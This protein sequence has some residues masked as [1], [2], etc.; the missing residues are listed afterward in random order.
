[1]HEVKINLDEFSS[2]CDTI[3]NLDAAT[4]GGIENKH[5]VYSH[6]FRAFD[7]DQVN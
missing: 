6:L 2:K 7:I 4:L 3:F 5:N 1:M